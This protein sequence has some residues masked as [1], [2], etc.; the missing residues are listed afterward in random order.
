MRR[1]ILLLLLALNVVGLVAL[2]RARP[3]AVDFESVKAQVQALDLRADERVWERIHWERD[4]ASAQ[5]VSR[6]TQRPIFLFS[7][8]G[9]LD[10]RC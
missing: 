6:A 3:P 10:G 8:W 9:E 5:E 1:K 2:Q 7:M 4:L